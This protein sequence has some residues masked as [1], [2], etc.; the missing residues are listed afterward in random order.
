MKAL[1]VL[2]LV[3]LLVAIGLPMGM[4]KMGDCP[5]CTSLRTIALGMCAGLLS[6][7]ILIVLLGSSRLRLGEQSS[8]LLLLS[9][10]VYRPPRAA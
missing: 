3:I 4:G 6:L 5:M 8:K 7:F 10:S 9:R 1:L 2:I